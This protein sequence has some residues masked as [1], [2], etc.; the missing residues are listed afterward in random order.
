MPGHSKR[1]LFPEQKRLTW[2]RQMNFWHVLTS[3]L[4]SHTLFSESLSELHLAPKRLFIV[5]RWQLRASSLLSE[6][7]FAFIPFRDILYTYTHTHVQ[8]LFILDKEMYLINY[9]ACPVARK[10]VFYL[11]QIKWHKLRFLRV[12]KMKI[13]K[14][15]LQLHL[16]QREVVNVFCEH[17]CLSF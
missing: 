1:F 13:F 2:W 14:P 9:S 8:Q 16:N 15:S 12:F 4:P 17:S 5:M 10:G 3:I 11:V 6:K 7:M